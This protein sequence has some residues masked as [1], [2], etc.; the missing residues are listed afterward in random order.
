MPADDVIYSEGL[1]LAR[2]GLAVHWLH[3]RAKVP[4]CRDWQQPLP[5]ALRLQRLPRQ[6]RALLNVGICTGQSGAQLALVVLDIDDE[7]AHDHALGRVSPSPLRVATRQGEQ[8]YYRHPGTGITVPTRAKM[9]G[10]RLDLR[11]ELGQV[12]CPPS[13]HP[14]GIQYRWIDE[15]TEALLTRLPVWK[16]EWFPVRVPPRV[17]PPALLPS[18]AASEQRL[19]NRGRARARRW[20]VAEE[21][22]GRGTQ[23]FLLACILVRE[24]GLSPRTAFDIVA[25]EYNP[26][27]PQP[28][29]EISLHRKINEAQKGRPAEAGPGAARAQGT[30]RCI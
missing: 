28:Y 19:V 14:T 6:F 3:P 15:P 11:G 7:R 21:S 16:P 20:P 9:D 4:I 2:M 24:L 12:V 26:R 27:L 13:I 30:N 25:T 22:H 17:L 5:S 23:T 1:R 18:H 10:Y 8:W 29:D